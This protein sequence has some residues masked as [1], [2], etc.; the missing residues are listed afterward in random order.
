MIRKKQARKTW[1]DLTPKQQT[2]VLTLGSIQIALAVTAWT[3]LVFRPSGQ[4]RGSKAKWAGVIAVN[5]IGP[6]FYF[7]RGIRR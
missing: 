4:V 3:D 1:H 5:F 2:A 7:A 6:I